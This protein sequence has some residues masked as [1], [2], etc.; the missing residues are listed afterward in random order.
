[1]YS[2]HIGGETGHFTLVKVDGGQLCVEY[3][4]FT[5]LESIFFFS[6]SIK[7]ISCLLEKSIKK[8]PSEIVEK[9]I[10]E[11]TIEKEEAAIVKEE[12]VCFWTR[13]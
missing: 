5:F 10:V 3:D 12:P 13:F 6:F 4:Y 11:E 9:V 7:K 2:Q 1:L 8:K